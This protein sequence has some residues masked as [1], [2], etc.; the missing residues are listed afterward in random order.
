MRRDGLIDLND[1]LQHPG[2]VAAE[3]FST[4]LDSEE[5][6]GLVE[7]LTGELEAVSTG[8][9]L[10]ISAEISTRVRTECSLCG[11]PLEVD[12]QF[13]MEDDFVVEG[14]ASSYAREGFAK[15]VDDEPYPLFKDNALIR[16]EYLRQGL[17]LNLPMQPEC[18]PEDQEECHRLAGSLKPEDLKP[19]PLK[20]LQAILP[21]GEASA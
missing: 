7:P 6:L 18:P 21:P 13:D 1:A 10:I 3:S 5:D 8:N 12:L 2:R 16:D 19:A 17:I 9:A 14:L 11:R 15:V 4:M 20:G